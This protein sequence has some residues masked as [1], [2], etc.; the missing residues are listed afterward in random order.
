MWKSRG[1]RENVLPQAIHN[2]VNKS[3]R[4]HRSDRKKERR[5]QV[6][7]NATHNVCRVSQIRKSKIE[8]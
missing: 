6:T 4:G 8:S 5:H 1:G 3:W 7:D 2:T